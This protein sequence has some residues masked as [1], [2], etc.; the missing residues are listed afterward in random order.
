MPIFGVAKVDPLYH[1][2]LYFIDTPNSS[3]VG[4][5]LLCLRGFCAAAGFLGGV[6]VFL[7]IFLNF[8]LGLKIIIYCISIL[9]ESATLVDNTA[10]LK[11][12]H[13]LYC[14]LQLIISILHGL[15]SPAAIGIMSLGLL[16]SITFN[17]ASLRMYGIIPMPMFLFYPVVAAI[18]PLLAH[19][20]LPE[21]TMAYETTKAITQTWSYTVRHSNSP[22]HTKYIL[23]KIKSIRPAGFYA[24]I[25]GFNLYLLKNSTKSTYYWIMVEYTLDC[26]LSIPQSAVDSAFSKSTGIIV[27]N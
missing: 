10:T 22:K 3:P 19:T 12:H 9:L 2:Q 4:L 27:N 26:L 15:V 16:V 6:R 18:V 21:G 23:K 17:F 25:G 7:T 8:I 13:S 1:V 24:G 11:R 14:R 5:I 20:L